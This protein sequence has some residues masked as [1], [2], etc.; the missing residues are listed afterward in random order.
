MGKEEGS[1]KVNDN[2]EL[3]LEP[4]LMPTPLEFTAAKSGS[5]LRPLPASTSKFLLGS[6]FDR[7][8][9]QLAQIEGTGLGRI[10]N[11]P[12]AS[13]MVGRLHHHH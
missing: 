10:S 13:K 1:T 2:D 4:P 7:L 8:L 5:G 3:L 9:G 12:P 6:G 11:N